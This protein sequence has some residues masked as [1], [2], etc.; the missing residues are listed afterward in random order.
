MGSTPGG[1]GPDA[2][3]EFDYEAATMAIA[4]LLRQRLD[5]LRG[6]RA[7]L[8]QVEADVAD[9]EPIVR[10]SSVSAMVVFVLI[11]RNQNI[12]DEEQIAFT[13]HF[14]DRSDCNRREPWPNRSWV[15]SAIHLS[16]SRVSVA[17]PR[18]STAAS[19]RSRPIRVRT[20]RP[21]CARLVVKRAA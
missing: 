20:A 1:Q 14:G 6:G 15:C 10:F 5:D 18:R 16:L 17:A 4:H 8:H 3:V 11:F 9:A 12:T 13:R 7:V 2:I 19:G 21:F